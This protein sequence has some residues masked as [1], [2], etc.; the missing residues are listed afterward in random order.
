M[1]KSAD[2]AGWGTGSHV[3]PLL[4]VLVRTPSA[5][6][7]F[8]AAGWRSPDAGLLL[9]EHEQFVSLLRSLGCEVVVTPAVPGLVDACYTH[10]P[11]VMTPAGAVIVQMRKA[12]R[13]SEPKLLYAELQRLGV[14]ILGALTGEAYMDGGDKVWLDEQPLLI[15]RGYRTNAAA[16]AQMRALVQPLG[17]RVEV[18][19][20]PHHRGP[21]EV[22]HLMSVVSPLARD[23]VAVFE[24]LAPVALMEL[25]QA[26]GVKRVPIA[27]EELATQ[28][29]NILAVAPRVVVV[30][31]GNPV[32]VAALR[33]AGCDVHEF[34][35]ANIC[36]KGDGGP[37]CLTQPLL[38]A[39][40]SDPAQ[41]GRSA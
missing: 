36:V 31:S 39:P 13:V 41:E 9:R 35:A 12:V 15:G 17:V 8:A 6:G 11:V 25:L 18:F 33:A 20:L 3:E 7:D 34:D 32:T 40:C 10:D 37:T 28:G 19:D 16:I 2:R 5:E 38:R 24:P 1:R 23:L 30:P 4:R 26:H 27:E 14:P 22:L 29:G 21:D